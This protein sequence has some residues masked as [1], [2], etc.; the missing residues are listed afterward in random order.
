MGGLAAGSVYHYRLMASNAVGT[1]FGNDRSLTTAAIHAATSRI[2]ASPKPR[3]VAAG[4][5]VTVAEV[6]ESA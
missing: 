1:S 3:V 6:E 4:L 5:P 2:S